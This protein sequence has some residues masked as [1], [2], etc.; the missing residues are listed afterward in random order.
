MRIFDGDEQI[1]AMEEYQSGIGISRNTKEFA[2]TFE[3]DGRKIT[4]LIDIGGMAHIMS[5]FNEILKDAVGMMPDSDG[6]IIH[7]D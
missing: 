4:V 3:H 6:Y 2:F 1:C 7:D 5:G